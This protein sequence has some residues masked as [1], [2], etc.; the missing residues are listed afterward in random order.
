MFSLRITTLSLYDKPADFHNR[1]ALC[2]CDTRTELLN[3]ILMV[4]NIYVL[5]Y[6]YLSHFYVC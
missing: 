2:F 4:F 5:D 3:I 6:I 1:D